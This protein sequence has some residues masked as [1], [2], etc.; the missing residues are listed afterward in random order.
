MSDANSRKLY[1]QVIDAD[2]YTDGAPKKTPPNMYLGWYIENAI[3]VQ[4]LLDDTGKPRREFIKGEPIKSYTLLQTVSAG[5]QPSQKNLLG[6]E[7]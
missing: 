3:N 2:T 1:E 7:Q 4:L 6:A 5:A